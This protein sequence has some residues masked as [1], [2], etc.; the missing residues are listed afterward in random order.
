MPLCHMDAENGA[1]LLCV[2]EV[3]LLQR[4]LF[5]RVRIK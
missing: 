5:S 3:D 1:L 4:A 2:Q